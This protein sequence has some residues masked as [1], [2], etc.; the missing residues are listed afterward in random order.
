[1]WTNTSL[2]AF[3][4]VTAHWIEAIIKETPNGPQKILNMQADLVGFHHIPGNHT[5]K[6]LAHAFLFITDCLDITEKV[7]SLLFVL[8][9]LILACQDWVDYYGQC[10]KQ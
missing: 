4:A 10:I 9:F 2:V 5:G 1:M 8:I 6:H 7:S 3:L